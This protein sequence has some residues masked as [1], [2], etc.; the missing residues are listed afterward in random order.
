MV[1]WYVRQIKM[2]RMTLDNVPKRW[3]DKVEAALKKN[4]EN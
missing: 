3:H 4:A 2:G 1:A